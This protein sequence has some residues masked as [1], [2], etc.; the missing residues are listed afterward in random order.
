MQTEVFGVSNRTRVINMIKA[1]ILAAV[2]VFLL[3]LVW[4]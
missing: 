4:Q 3:Y 2:L 1:V